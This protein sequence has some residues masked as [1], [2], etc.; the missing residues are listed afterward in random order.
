M[1]EI[2]YQLQVYKKDTWE[3]PEVYHYINL[4]AAKEC[5]SRLLNNPDCKVDAFRVIK[6]DAGHYKTMFYKEKNKTG[7]N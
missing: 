7:G 6:T 4:K 1:K 2:N 3:S 5:G